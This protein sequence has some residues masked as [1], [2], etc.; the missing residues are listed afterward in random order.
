MASY[1][2]R[3]PVVS[4]FSSRG[5]DYIDQKRSPADVLKPDILAPGHQIWAAWS[6]MSI[7]NPILSGSYRYMLAVCSFCC[8]FANM[9]TCFEHIQTGF[10]SQFCTNI[11]NQHGSP[12][13]CRHSC[14]HQA[15]SLHMDSINDCFSHVNHSYQARQPR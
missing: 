1:I 15:K 10:R 14:T 5:P 2:E 9:R 3:A 11:W 13:H 12:S 8:F 4:R 7:L 6:P